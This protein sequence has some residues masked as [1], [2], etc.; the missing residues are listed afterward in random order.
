MS[1]VDTAII[2]KQAYRKVELAITVMQVAA[3]A[4]EGLTGK[5]FDAFYRHQRCDGDAVLCWFIAEVQ[6]LRDRAAKASP[7]RRKGKGK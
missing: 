2:S 3:R 5:E 1:E 7:A 6:D 4:C